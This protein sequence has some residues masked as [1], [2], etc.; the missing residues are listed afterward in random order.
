MNEDHELS[1]EET[2]KYYL[3]PDDE[4]IEAEEESFDDWLSFMANSYGG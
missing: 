4:Y 3:W 1:F 2:C